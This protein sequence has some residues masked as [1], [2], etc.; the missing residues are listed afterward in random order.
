MIGNIFNIGSGHTRGEPNNTI[1]K[2]GKEA[3]TGDDV[4]QKTYIN[5]GPPTRSVAAN[6]S[7]HNKLEE[8]LSWIDRNK[9][10]TRINL[11]GHSRGSFLSLMIAT[12]ILNEKNAIV[13]NV[14]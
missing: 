4:N 5:E 9:G 14:N 13:T 2:L 7:L 3:E 10:I 6:L 8:T 1:A 11:A 12:Y